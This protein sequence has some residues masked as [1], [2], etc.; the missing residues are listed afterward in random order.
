MQLASVIKVS[1]GRQLNEHQHKE[2]VSS[3]LPWWRLSFGGCV[4]SQKCMCCCEFKLR[5]WVVHT[6]ECLF[7]R[8][9][10]GCGS[11]RRAG[12][13]LFNGNRISRMTVGWLFGMMG[14]QADTWIHSRTR[15]QK[16]PHTFKRTRD[17]LGTIR[18]RRVCE[19]NNMW[20]ASK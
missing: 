7:T 4:C 15:A 6:Y 2:T 1:S 18:D 8:S 19:A 17:M 10:R 12:L 13:L 5:G 20:T 9:L 14:N 16:F 11:V 3:P